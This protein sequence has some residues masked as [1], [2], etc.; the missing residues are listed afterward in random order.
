MLTEP[1]KGYCVPGLSFTPQELFEEIRKHHPGFG[2]RVELDEH[3]NKFANL[4]PDE[5]STE[6]AKRDLGY[7]P[8]VGLSEMVSFVLDAHEERNMSTAEAF[9]SIDI[10]GSGQ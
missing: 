5:L 9:K 6:E 4:W 3:M 2:F 10:D 7:S 8:R 1:E